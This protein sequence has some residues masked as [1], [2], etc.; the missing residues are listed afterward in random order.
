[1]KFVVKKTVGGISIATPG[2]VVEETP[3]RPLRF[4][5]QVSSAIA[6]GVALEITPTVSLDFFLL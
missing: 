1:M 6:P 5:E 2:I 3:S 4:L